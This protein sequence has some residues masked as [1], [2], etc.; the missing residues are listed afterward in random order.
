V[1]TPAAL[2]REVTATSSAEDYDG[3]E[4]ET[5]APVIALVGVA[6]R[7]KGRAI[8]RRGE[9]LKEIEAAKN[10]HDARSR[11]GGGAP[12]GRLDAAAAAGLSKD[13][14]VQALRVASV[15]APVF[16]VMVARPKPATVTELAESRRDGV[17]GRIV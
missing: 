7:I 16:E 13:Q 8:R 10:Q 9:L 12:T 5:P 15:P 11:A 14:T 3:D 6:M 1:V 4:W 2:L 17:S